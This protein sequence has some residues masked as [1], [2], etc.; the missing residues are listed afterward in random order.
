VRDI[1]FVSDEVTDNPKFDLHS[2]EGI[3][4]AVFHILR[5]ANVLQTQLNRTWWCAGA[6]TRSTA[7]NTTIRRSGLPAGL[8]ASTSAPAAARAP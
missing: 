5:N 3:T 1:V 4:D 6:A 2:T 8:A 7:P